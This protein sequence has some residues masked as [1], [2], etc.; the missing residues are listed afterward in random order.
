MESIFPEAKS[1]ANNTSVLVKCANQFMRQTCHESNFNK[2]NEKFQNFIKLPTR[3][4]FPR[5]RVKESNWKAI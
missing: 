1:I 3:F 2:T 4:F 5:M